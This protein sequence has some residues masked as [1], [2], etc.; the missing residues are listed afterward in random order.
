MKNLEKWANLLLKL[1]ETKKVKNIWE[2]ISYLQ[3]RTVEKGKKLNEALIW[4]A[5]TR[6]EVIGKIQLDK[7]GNFINKPPEKT[8]YAMVI[9]PKC[10]QIQKYK[11]RGGRRSHKYCNN[12]GAHFEINKI[13]QDKLSNELRQFDEEKLKEIKLGLSNTDKEILTAFYN[14]KEKRFEDRNQKQISEI[15][16]YHKSTISRHLKELINKSLV[17]NVET[18]ISNFAITPIQTYRINP[19]IQS[20]QNPEKDGKFNAVQLHNVKVA[21]PLLSGNISA[22]LYYKW[23][24][25]SKMRNWEYRYFTLYDVEFAVSTKHIFFNTVGIGRSPSSAMKNYEEKAYRIRDHLQTKLGI[26]LGAPK[27]YLESKSGKKLPHYV[28]FRTDKTTFEKLQRVWTDRSHPG[29]IETESQEF[30]K[31]LLGMEAVVKSLQRENA[32]LKTRLATFSHTPVSLKPEFENFAKDIKTQFTAFKEEIRNDMLSIAKMMAK[33]FVSAM[34][35]EF[36]PNPQIHT[37]PPVD[38]YI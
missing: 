2:A 35:N 10:K 5:T 37:D 32:Q 18:R 31:R 24:K 36:Q 38:S 23:D 12:C 28:P 26:Q 14:K 22:Q 3:K 15:T 34:K 29:A 27:F 9:C 16:G 1:I 8:K 7:D 6:L 4:Q 21:L 25:A 19:S 30:V 13:Q 33:E 17:I 11:N 20:P